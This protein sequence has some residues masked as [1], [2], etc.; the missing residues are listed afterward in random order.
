[1]PQSKRFDFRLGPPIVPIFQIAGSWTREV[2]PKKILES[3]SRFTL[4]FFDSPK[5]SFFQGKI[6][7]FAATTIA[8]GFQKTP[9]KQAIAT[10]NKSGKAILAV[11]VGDK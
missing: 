11:R 7:F 4:I 3:G 2:N 9:K 10:N 6:N 5:N 1:M 8:L